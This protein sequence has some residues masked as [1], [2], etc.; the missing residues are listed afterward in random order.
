MENKRKFK[1]GDLVN[2]QLKHNK[3]EKGRVQKWS[4]GVYKIINR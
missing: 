3:L 2:I 4:D 1:I